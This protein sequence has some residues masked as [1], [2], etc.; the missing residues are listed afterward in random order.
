MA[1]SA[2]FISLL[3]AAWLPV[4]AIAQSSTVAPVFQYVI[5]YSLNLEIAAAQPFVAVGPVFTDGSM[6]SGSANVTFSNTVWCVGTNVN[7]G[8]DPFAYNYSGTASNYKY[9]GQPVTGVNPI[10]F[11]TATNFT[12]TNNLHTL[13]DLPPPAYALG[14]PSAYTTNGQTYIANEADLIISNAISGTN[15]GGIL[16]GTNFTVYY[17][18][19]TMSPSLMKVTNDFYIVTNSALHITY[20]TNYIAPGFIQGN[21]NI[22]YAGYTFLTNVLFYDWR[23]GWNGGSGV[24]G[25]GKPVQAIQFSVTNFNAWLSNSNIN[26]TI[27]GNGG[28]SLNNLCQSHKGHPID[29]IYLYTSVT[30]MTGSLPAVR[31]VNGAKLYDSHG[32]TIA[33]PFP[34][35]VLGNYNVM[36]GT[37]SNAGQNATTHT[38]PAGLFAD[39]ITVLSSNW[40]DSVTTKTPISSSINTINAAIMA[41]IVPSNPTIIA[42]DD[43]SYSGGVENFLRLLES[44]GGTQ[45]LYFNGSIVVPFSSEYATN[46][47]RQTGNFYTAPYRNWAFD[48]NFEIQA[49]LPPMTPEVF[50]IV[51]P[52]I[53]TQPQS[54]TNFSGN[55][56]ILNVSTLGAPPFSYQWSF[57]EENIS[58]ATNQSLILTNVQSSQSGI[59]AVQVTN[60]FGSILSSN[61]T[62]TVIDQSPIILSQPTSQAVLFYSNATFN[63]AV[64]GSTPLSYQW[65][66]NDLDID[67]ATNAS[68]TLSNVQVT[69]AGNYAVQIT[70]AFGLTNSF[71]AALTVITNPPVIVIQPSNQTAFISDV[72]TFPVS[73]T[74]SPVL[75]YQWSF[76]GTNIDSATNANLTIPYAQFTNAG[77]YSVVITNA[78]GSVVSSN[79]VLTVNP[80]TCAPVSAG[81]VAWW[82]AEGDASDCMGNNNGSLMGGT[83]FAVGKV[84]QAFNFNG[85]NSYVL[86]SNSPSIE[87]TG[88][89]TVEAW[90]NYLGFAGGQ[91]GDAIV[92][93]GQDVEGPIDWAMSV[94]STARLRV[95]LHM[96]SNWDQFDGSMILITNTWYHVAMV[97]DGTNLISYVDGVTN[98]SMVVPGTLQ[99]T[100]YPLKIGAYSPTNGVQSKD[101]FNGQIDEV[102]IYNRALSP[103]E[104]LS[105]Y[106]A[107][108]DGK[109]FPIAPV[110]LSQPTNQTVLVGNTASFQVVAS[111]TSPLNYQWNFN[112]TNIS[113]ATNT[114]F[115]LA[116][117]QLSDAGNYFV[118]V[119]NIADNVTSSNA[120]LSVYSSA[121]PIMNAVSFSG[122][123]GFQF[124]V[125]GVPGFNYAVQSSTNLINW[126]SLIT[127]P[128]PFNFTDTNAAEFPQQFYRSVYF[129]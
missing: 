89:F 46:R 32:L 36:D 121:V 86:V 64:T 66:F 128:S 7:G 21:T 63:V 27:N 73:V 6:W 67:G 111:G 90:V 41:G 91:T 44:W 81:L 116:G 84:G 70:N 87:P 56:A 104:I 78:F 93:K 24:N 26:G 14:S 31:V 39:A 28:K 16:R 107:R 45:H 43:S 112:G 65:N 69:Q 29:G 117:A 101:W 98:G 17:Q 113:G 54:K 47:W 40:N 105:I 97:Y 72:V 9:P 96:G 61:A 4:P 55:T 114:S 42:S 30:N 35:Y 80:I 62:L 83:S 23:E 1:K 37:G 3:L 95:H 10:Y 127:N 5:F 20:F 82:R 94:G 15:W 75:S 76:D 22:F 118:V 59:Y 2:L 123:N 120:V 58:G 68:L 119:T 60:A 102:S 125:T 50:Q 8:N 19:S 109:C 12:V 77:I 88:P 103:A 52:F 79:A 92:A 53:V 33:T 57:N 126:Q 74:G 49:D 71:I 124:A 85:S 25:K 51:A 38:Y 129:P 13:L 108:S 18:D 11:L 48:T 100:S 106:N 122:G 110:I 34:L 99:A 115:T